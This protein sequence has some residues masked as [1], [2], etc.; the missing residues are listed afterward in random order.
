MLY[1]Q[2]KKEKFLENWT[3]KLVLERKKKRNIKD[4][5]NYQSSNIYISVI[6]TSYIISTFSLMFQTCQVFGNV[7]KGGV[8][9]TAWDPK[10]ALLDA[11][12]I[13]LQVL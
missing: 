8:S 7:K 13:I 11:A 9:T 1:F 4:M 2:D 12:I 6:F 3:V 5:I 10:R